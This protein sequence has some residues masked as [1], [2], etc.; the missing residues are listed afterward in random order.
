MLSK[1]AQNAL[2]EWESHRPRIVKA[3]FKTKVM[4]MNIIQY[5]APTNGS[6]ENDK[7]Q[8]YERLQLIIAK[9]P[10]KDLTIVMEDLNAKVR[11]DN[12]GYEDIM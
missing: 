8:F 11:T 1:E 7:D 10:R 12:T 3:F 5:Y 6:N 4:L 2:I 9:C